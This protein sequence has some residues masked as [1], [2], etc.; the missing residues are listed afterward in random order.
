MRQGDNTTTT[1]VHGYPLKDPNEIMRSYGRY[2]AYSQNKNPFFLK[3]TVRVQ[4]SLC[5]EEQSLN[6]EEGREKENRA[7]KG[8]KRE[9][10]ADKYRE[11]ETER[12]GKT[13]IPCLGNFHSG[14]FLE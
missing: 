7:G 14:Q 13:S 3:V 6:V 5:R 1:L 8:R 9:R 4:Y 10:Q 12:R 2:K 11:T